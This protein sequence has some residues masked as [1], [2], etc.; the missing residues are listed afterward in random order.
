MHLVVRL[1]DHPL[2]LYE[3]LDDPVGHVVGH[4]VVGGAR[5]AAY[6][7]TCPGR[8]VPSAPSSCQERPFSSSGPCR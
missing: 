1:S 5:A 2:R 3:H 7:A 6:C 4:A 8:P